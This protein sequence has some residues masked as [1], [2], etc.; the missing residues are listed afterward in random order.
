M[1]RSLAR[2]GCSLALGALVAGFALLPPAQG[3]PSMDRPEPGDGA[4]ATPTNGTLTKALV[5]EL[6]RRNLEVTLGYTR[7]YVQE[8]CDN[9]TYPKMRN[10]FGNNPASPYQ[11]V[12]VK[13]WRNEYAD[14]RT[15]DAFGK[16]GPRFTAFPRLD[17]REAIIVMGTMPPPARYMGLQT[18][19]MT[20]QGRW[21][22]ESY[23]EIAQVQPELVKFLFTAVPPSDRQTGRLVSFSSVNNNI[24]NVVIQRKSGSVWGQD[25]SFIITPDQEMDRTVRSSLQSLGVRDKDV[26]TGN[27]PPKDENRSIGPLGLGKQA[28]D[29][30]T[31]LRYTMPEDKAAGDAWMENPPLTVLRVRER[32]SSQRAPQPFP[33]YLLEKRTGVPEQ[34]LAGSQQQLVKAVCARAGRGPWK[35]DT[36]N[37]GCR[38]KAP[39]PNS[40]MHDLLNELGQSGPECRSIGMDCLGDNQDASYFFAPARPLDQGQVYALVGT[41]ATETGNGTY[42]G[43]S[44]NDASRLKGV[45]NVPDTDKEAPWADLTG[46]ADRYTSVKNRD[47]LFVHYFSRNCRGLRGLTGGAC[48]TI[49]EDM[50]ARAGDDSAQGDPRAHGQVNFALRTY[51][52]PGSERGP[53]PKLQLKGRVLTFV[54]R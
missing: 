45:F 19:I 18:W 30:V 27:I 44:V 51:V 41:L 53:D 40:T 2:A 1:A 22:A 10:C 54:R 35:F 16:T 26:F 3:R 36:K 33:P 7:L 37:S 52:K 13:R 6:K 25:R 12:I 14:P 43:L 49:T 28:N 42:V 38:E 50:V 46:S 29:F 34:W 23:D 17:R 32:P 9:Y 11:T 31:L 5:R 24:N 15:K 39:Y 4:A 48:T 47:K 8:D 20:K 21:T